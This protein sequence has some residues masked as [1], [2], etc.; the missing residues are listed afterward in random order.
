[1]L[2]ENPITKGNFSGL[3]YAR[4]DELDAGAKLAVLSVDIS[5]YHWLLAMGDK[6]TSVEFL[7]IPELK[8]K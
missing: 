1:M 6:D 5:Q 3:H 7:I 4:V 2:R 8:K